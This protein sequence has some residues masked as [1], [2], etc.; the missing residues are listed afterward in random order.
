VHRWIVLVF[1]FHFIEACSCFAM[2][3]CQHNPSANRCPAHA[4]GQL[5]DSDLL[6]LF[7][8]L[9]LPELRHD[10][11]TLDII[12]PSLRLRRKNRPTS[13]GSGFTTVQ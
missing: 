10:G 4:Q 5:Y 8:M 2:R 7:E 6:N 9:E 1:V 11:P 3:F 12:D 13:G